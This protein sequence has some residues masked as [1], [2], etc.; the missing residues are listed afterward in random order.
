MTTIYDE[1]L[2][3]IGF[4]SNSV[5]I[6]LFCIFLIIVG[7]ILLSFEA[8]NYNAFVYYNILKKLKQIP[9]VFI[10]GIL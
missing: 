5:Q 4:P 9:T 10:V 3:N 6:F 1:I 7:L 8:L 2:K